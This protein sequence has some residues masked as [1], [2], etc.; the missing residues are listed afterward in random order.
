MVLLNV[1][2]SQELSPLFHKSLVSFYENNKMK[3]SCEKRE[4]VADM[5]KIVNSHTYCFYYDRKN[6]NGI[7]D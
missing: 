3:Y 5:A 7:F 6:R 2:L 4:N 1:K